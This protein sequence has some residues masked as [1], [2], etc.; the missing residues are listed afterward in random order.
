MSTP[1]P[2][3]N[4]VVRD[5]RRHLMIGGLAAVI[6]VGG[7]GGLAATTN[8]SGAVLSQGKLVVT[9]GVSSVKHL[10]GGVITQILVR[11]GDAVHA[12]DVLVRL[13]ATQLSAN[14]AVIDKSLLELWVKRA[15]LVAERSGAAA[16]WYPD[17]VTRS[18]DQRKAQLMAAEDHAFQLRSAGTAGRKA[19]FNERIEQ[20][21]QQLDGLAA[22]EAAKIVEH[23]WLDKELTAARQS[24]SK[25][26]IQ[27]SRLSELERT[28][29]GIQGELGQLRSSMGDLRGKIAEINLQIAQVD[30]DARSAV[31]SELQ[32]V[33]SRIAELEERQRAAND[34]LQRVDIRAPIDGY[35]YELAVNSPGAII[36]PGEQLMTIV[37][38]SN[39]LVVE[40][41]ILPQN[42]DQ[43]SMGQA[44]NLR[45]SA[46]DQRTT[47]EL[48]GQVEFVS[49]DL[50]LD[51]GTGTSFY[52][53]RISVAPEQWQRLGNLKPV[54]GMPVETFIHTG[55]RSMLSYLVQP[56]GDQVARAFRE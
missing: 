33:E 30:D 9:G 5:I 51:P 46:F 18:P 24:W 27:F 49:P 54:P 47:P 7:V 40:T 37:P 43:L 12:G 6:L 14:L 16:V 1:S 21:N 45:F 32:D 56:L 52:L 48:T 22:A 11:D 13:D 36:G 25:Q 42:I 17:A 4:V 55:D 39:A 2:H 28:S 44:S 10:T 3:L 34:Q 8:I 15:R 41:R 38:S 50:V 23:D 53:A 26:L 29:A 31:A 19:Q 35:V 20:I